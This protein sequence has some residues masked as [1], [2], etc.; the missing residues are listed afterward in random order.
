MEGRKTLHKKFF[1]GFPQKLNSNLLPTDT[2]VVN[3]TQHLKREKIGL[4]EWKPQTPVGEIARVVAV[5]VCSVWEK[6]DIPHFGS[7][8]PKWVKEKVEK[9]LN[10]AKSVLKTPVER[11]NG[12]E[13]EGQWSNLFDISICPHRKNKHCDCPTAIHLTLSHVTVKWRVGYQMSG[14]LSCGT[15]GGKGSNVS[16]P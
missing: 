8:N 9:L 3:H 4:G 7:N 15:R 1:F 14:G 12:E 5:D 13:I 11:R 16:P 6:T 2:Y 10:K